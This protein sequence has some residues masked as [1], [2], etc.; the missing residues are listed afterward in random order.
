MTYSQA[1]QILKD[2][3]K[4]DGNICEQ[5]CKALDIAISVMENINLIRFNVF[6]IG[7]LIEYGSGEDDE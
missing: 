3:R 6:A 7:E 4:H 5:D 2:L 1:L